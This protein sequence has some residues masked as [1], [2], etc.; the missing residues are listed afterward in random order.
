MR[1]QL[2]N[3]PIIVLCGGQGTRLRSILSDRPKVLAPIGNET[4]LDI[5]VRQ[6][7]EHGFESII[8][9][10]GYLKE[11]VKKHCAQFSYP[12]R[13]SEEDKPLGTGGA[14]RVA[15]DHVDADRF[16]VMNGDMIFN[17]DFGELFRFHQ[18]KGG[19]VSMALTRRYVGSGGNVV[20]MNEEGRIVGWR[21][22][23]DADNGES[24]H[25]NA[26]TYLIERPAT[27]FFPARKQFSLEQDFFPLVFNERCFGFET[28]AE[29]IDIGVPERYQTALHMIN[30]TS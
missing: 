16:F 5:I 21:E 12:V 27:R 11:Q 8:L 1:E 4:L 22:K 20:T 18:E 2:R 23:T 28:G 3:T 19:V 17:P 29:F 9:S 10:I 14:V 13:F 25:L 7:R 15:L 6:L 26:G 24:V 30:T